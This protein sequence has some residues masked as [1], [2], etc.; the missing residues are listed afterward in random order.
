MKKIGKEVCFLKTKIGNIRN[1]EGS[2]IRLLDGRIMFAY[3]RYL[4]NDWSDHSI[5]RIEAIYSN[6][7]GETWSKTSPL[8]EKTLTRLT[9][10]R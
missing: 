1:G 9:L 10:C 7:E 5:A 2:F 6:D 4:S 8:I 3:T